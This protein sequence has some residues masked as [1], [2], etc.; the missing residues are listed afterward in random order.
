VRLRV[1]VAL[2][3]LFIGAI[4]L[5]LAS[6]LGASLGVQVLVLIAATYTGTWVGILVGQLLLRGLRGSRQAGPKSD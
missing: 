5:W 4:G 3:G 2:V 6:T 1:G